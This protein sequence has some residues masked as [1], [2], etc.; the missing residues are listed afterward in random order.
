MKYRVSIILSSTIRNLYFAK[1]KS[2]AS[3]FSFYVKI[4][5]T[6]ATNRGKPARF[7]N[8]CWGVSDIM[9]ESLIVDHSR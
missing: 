1:A 6:Q 5:R 7:I 2:Y 3:F 4:K 8:F 9:T